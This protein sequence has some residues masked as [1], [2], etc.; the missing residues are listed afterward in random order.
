M[1]YM[2]CS[3]RNYTYFA[4]GSVAT[5]RRPHLHL[6]R[7][8]LEYRRVKGTHARETTDYVT[9]TPLPDNRIVPDGVFVLENRETDRRGLFFVE[10]DRGTER[11]TVASSRDNRATIRGKFIQYDRYLTS[12]R[13]A[14]TY[15]SFGEFRFF[16]L[17]FVTLTADR[18]DNIRDAVSDLPQTLHPYYRLTTFDVACNDFVGNVWK[19]R[20]PGDKIM[21][22]LVQQP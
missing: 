19:S 10:M 21:Y 7:T 15:A 5:H 8:F 2:L 22:A 12:G 13:F 16:T 11:I 3:W 6:V 18:V 20:D 14:Q 9:D 1:P 4:R 17:L